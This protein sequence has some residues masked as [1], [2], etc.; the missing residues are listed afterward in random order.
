MFA[1]R[2][3]ECVALQTIGV[4]EPAID[5]AGQVGDGTVC[6][7]LPE[8]FEFLRTGRSPGDAIESSRAPGQATAELVEMIRLPG[9]HAGERDDRGG[10]LFETAFGREQ[11][12]AN[13]QQA[14]NLG[15]GIGNKGI[16]IVP[17]C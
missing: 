17:R 14:V 1:D 15:W 3:E 4:S 5:C 11:P 8:S 7:A 6:Q 9:I 13:S 10:K 2:V 12:G 16:E